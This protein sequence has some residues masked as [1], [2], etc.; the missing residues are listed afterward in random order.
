M[1]VCHAGHAL[2]RIVCVLLSLSLNVFCLVIYNGNSCVAIISH[3]DS[4][5]QFKLFINA[6]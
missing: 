4:Y 6:I 2:Y 5:V 3:I 1:Q